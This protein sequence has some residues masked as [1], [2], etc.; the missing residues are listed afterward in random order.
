M[1]TFRFLLV[2]ILAFVPMAS[3]AMQ[4]VV[5]VIDGDTFDLGGE[6]IRLFGIDAPEGD[7][8]C[9]LSGQAWACGT[10]ATE[11]L[12]EVI[13]GHQLACKPVERDRFG[14]SVAICTAG[15]QDVAEAMVSRGAALAYRR[16]SARYIAAERI[17][18]AGSVG[19]WA[20]RMDT[21]EAHRK[22]RQPVPAE[23]PTDCRIKGNISQ[24]GRIY[25]LPGQEHYDR[26]VISP[27][28]GE[29]WFCSE[30]EA[31]AAGFRRARR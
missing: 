6:R 11:V 25:H 2:L 22:A 29:A 24:S 20:A 23:S 19:L 26:T 5:R 13:R 14:R 12:T 18:K 7:Q 4:G 16:Y 3:L 30:A 21:P 1:L 8:I 27:G 31:R 28:K 17:A 15:G 9:D 10:W